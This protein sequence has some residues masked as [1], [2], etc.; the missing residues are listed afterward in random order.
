MQDPYSYDDKYINLRFEPPG[1]KTDPK[2][3]VIIGWG[4]FLIQRSHVLCKKRVAGSKTAQSAIVHVRL[5][6]LS[7]K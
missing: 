2:T 6:D 1:A 3:L 7:S 5:K 4:L